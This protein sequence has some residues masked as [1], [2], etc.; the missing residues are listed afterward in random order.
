M[1]S[2]Q[3]L[4]ICASIHHH[5]TAKV[6]RVIGGVLNAEICTP[7]EVSPTNVADY[8]LIGVG[9]GI[10]FGRFHSSVRQWID[11]LSASPQK[12]FVFSTEGLPSL[13]RFWHWP[14][15]SMLLKKGF[16]VVG[17]FHCGGLDTVGPFLED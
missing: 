5:N 14:I 12:V 17:E 13:W 3:T 10:Y 1:L 15:K 4:I 16:T 6:A 2:L 7:E 9:S 11:R 8:N